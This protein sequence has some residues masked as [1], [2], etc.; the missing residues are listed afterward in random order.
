M[1]ASTFSTHQKKIGVFYNIKGIVIAQNRSYVSD[2]KFCNSYELV[3]SAFPQISST[4]N[5]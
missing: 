5:C 2:V 3:K 4:E 1:T